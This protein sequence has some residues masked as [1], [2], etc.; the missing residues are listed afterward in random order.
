MLNKANPARLLFSTTIPNEANKTMTE[1]TTQPQRSDATSVR[2]PADHWLIRC[3]ENGWLPDAVVRAGMRSLIRRRLDDESMPDVHRRREKIDTLVTELRSS[4][5][6]IDT[7]AANTQHYEVPNGFFKAHLGPRLKYSC[8]YYPRGD[9]TLA[10]AEDA[11]LSIYAERAQLADGQRVLDLGCGWGALSLWL[12]ER[13][14]R[15]RVV[16]LC[17]SQRQRQ[18]IEQ[19][20]AARGLTNVQVIVGNIVDF[21]FAPTEA[22]FDRVISIEMFEHMKNYG[23][24]LAKISRWLCDDGKLFVHHF[25]HRHLAYHFASKDSTDWMSRHFFTGGTMPNADLMLHFQ[26]HLRVSGHWWIDG[27][28]YER[29]ANQWLESLDAARSRALPTLAAINP[30]EARKRF[31]RW[32]LFYMAVAELF[33]YENGRQWG[34]VHCLFDQQRR[35]A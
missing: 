23:L 5:I 16:G 14:P 8:T 30:S 31:Q 12:A 24:L 9:E 34:V 3:A 18:F 1:I 4:P 21:E 20:A 19:C 28:H 13:Y 7:H 29:T 26:D 6:A 22:R 27:R 10:Q 35:P 15:S 17:N 33:G 2:E 25:A 11:M 32:R